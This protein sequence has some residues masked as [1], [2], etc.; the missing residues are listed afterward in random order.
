MNG[1]TGIRCRVLAPAT[2]LPPQ[3]QI[4][5]RFIANFTLQI[6]LLGLRPRCPQ[7]IF[8]RQAILCIPATPGGRDSRK[9][10]DMA[11]F[12]GSTTSG[13]TTCATRSR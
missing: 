9:L 1:L 11:A 8:T 12:T 3:E 4:V 10:S 6:A 2:F 5:S 13:L 7:A